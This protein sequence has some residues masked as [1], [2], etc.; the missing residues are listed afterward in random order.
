MVARLLHFKDRDYI[1]Q[2]ART[3]GNLV[4]ENNRFSIFPYFSR[5]VQRQRAAFIT[6]KRQLRELGIVYSMQFPATPSGDTHRGAILLYPS[7]SMGLDGE[8][9]QPRPERPTLAA[10]EEAPT[11]PTETG[12]MTGPP[13]EKEVQKGQQEA[14]VAAASLGGSSPDHGSS[15]QEA[16]EDRSELDRDSMPFSEIL[17]VVTRGT[18]DELI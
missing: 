9:A 2:R 4:V 11:S 17:P 3:G 8:A 6:M 5:E 15:L 13:T 7:G 16:S 14:V 18:A 12:C 10:E 1:L